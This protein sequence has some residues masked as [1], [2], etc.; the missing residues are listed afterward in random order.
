MSKILHLEVH[1]KWSGLR[2]IT[3][4]Q[5]LP[6]Q[7][8]SPSPYLMSEFILPLLS[9]LR[10]VTYI[11]FHF[12]SYHFGLQIAEKVGPGSYSSTCSLLAL[13]TPTVNFLGY[14]SS[15][16]N[17][18]PCLPAS[19]HL[20]SL[21]PQLLRTGSCLLYSDPLH[22][23]QGPFY[24]SFTRTPNLNVCSSFGSPVS[25]FL[26]PSTFGNMKSL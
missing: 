8:P 1:T 19:L 16:Q 14:H 25:S 11:H 10:W 23:S 20:S 6:Q 13:V 18:P 7:S 17:P 4:F 3:L 9:S 21:P 26:W 22:L 2:I 15:L 24:L 12:F 5:M